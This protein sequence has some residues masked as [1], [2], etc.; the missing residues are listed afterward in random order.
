M[1]KQSSI[2]RN[3]L[4][5]DSLKYA[6]A[7][8]NIDLT[9]GEEDA[10][11]KKEI[12]PD[13]LSTPPP[14]KSRS[15]SKSEPNPF[16]LEEEN[17]DGDRKQVSTKNTPNPVHISDT[18]QSKVRPGVSTR[19][20]FA[21]QPSK[22]ALIIIDIQE[23][24]SQPPRYSQ[25]DSHQSSHLFDVALPKS[26]PNIEKLARNVRNN[27][28]G[29][30][31]IFTYL[32]ALT[33]DCRDVSLDYKL[34][35][36]L[37]GTQLPGPSNPAKFL[38]RLTP[39]RT[40]DILIPKT[41]CSVF[42]STNIHYV[43]RNLNI[44]QVVLCGQL[45]NQCVESAARDAADLGYFVTIPYD[46]CAALS[47][48]DHEKGLH[49]MKGFARIISTEQ[50]MK[51]MSTSTT[52]EASQVS[53]ELTIVSR[54]QPS[55]T[56]NELVIS[57]RQPFSYGQPRADIYP[58]RAPTLSE[59]LEE[60]YV[61]ESSIYVGAFPDEPPIEGENSPILETSPADSAT[62][63]QIIPS[64]FPLLNIQPVN[65]YTLP[66]PSN[67]AVVSLLRTLQLFGVKFIRVSSVDLC[68]SVRCKAIPIKYILSKPN[69]EKEFP[70]LVSLAEVV[71][72]GLPS[73]ADALVPGSGLDGSRVLY[74]QPDLSTLRVLP[75]AP[76]HAWVFGSAQDLITGHVS[77]YCTRS[78]LARVKHMAAQDFGLEF[79]VGAEIEFQLFSSKT[80]S[81]NECP[82][83]SSL[84]AYTNT[85]NDQ[86]NF[87]NDLIDQLERQN[88]EIE[89][90]HSESAA[91]QLEV[92][93][94]YQK[95]ITKIADDI[96]LT[97]EVRLM[98]KYNVEYRAYFAN[99]YYSLILVINHLLFFFQT[100]SSCAKKHKL[101]A[102]FLPKVNSMQGGNALHLH[103]SFAD[104]KAADPDR[105]A[106]TSKDGVY[107]IS[108]KG[109]RFMVRR[110]KSSF[111]FLVQF[112]L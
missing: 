37:L 47:A 69:P 68:N 16:Q 35:G 94:K 56:S 46:A 27:R 21:L 72:G 24:L 87:T 62:E 2:Y 101:K 100:I 103:F 20:D 31:V 107:G 6:E 63:P 32:E 3:V 38:S 67:G 25:P 60:R 108:E 71:M 4:K 34:S 99:S 18:I 15:W 61:N 22:M 49:G 1:K 111:Y 110:V 41:S 14:S 48:E 97:R 112:T 78:L 42:L 59:T 55:H 105:N 54:S 36:R 89:L 86:E 40:T 98:S 80:G 45:T 26:L 76:S 74:L 84:F 29:G 106:F 85:L 43:L 73:Y 5:P 53:N 81:D 9:S 79:H 33:D 66:P 13:V 102:I 30:Q 90:I 57:S 12:F 65:Q 52:I 10:A 77:P 11:P 39:D 109:E 28:N 23:F 88:I 75:Y 64:I 96:I 51:E 91:G 83:D 58:A 93:L 19:Y 104:L 8:P 82:V 44:E 70:K 7:F 17:E 95:D 50:V 92:V